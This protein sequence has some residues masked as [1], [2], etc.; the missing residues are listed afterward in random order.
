MESKKKND[1]NEIIYKTH[2]DSQSEKTNLWLPNGKEREGYLRSL[3]PLYIKHVNN[4]HLWYSTET[5]TQYFIITYKG[6]ESEKK[7][8]V[9]VYN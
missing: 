4:K 2:I 8:C 9:C 3:G 5:Y 1:T 7:V 6:K